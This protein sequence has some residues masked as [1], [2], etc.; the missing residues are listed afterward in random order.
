MGQ[1]AFPVLG[2]CYFVPGPVTIPAGVQGKL[3]LL[4]GRVAVRQ[5]CPSA[6]QT[7]LFEF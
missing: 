6:V 3:G 4:G 5:W 1:V 2:T 7:T